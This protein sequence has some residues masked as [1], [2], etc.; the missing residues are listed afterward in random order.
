MAF[1]IKSQ[2]GLLKSQAIIE[3]FKIT[4]KFYQGWTTNQLKPRYN[5]S[6]AVVVSK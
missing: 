1:G 6:N 2:L 5:K 4:F 3:I